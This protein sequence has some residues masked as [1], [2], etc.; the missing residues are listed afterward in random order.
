MYVNMG[1]LLITETKEILRSQESLSSSFFL[2]HIL[3]NP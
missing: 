2:P 3:G 1:K